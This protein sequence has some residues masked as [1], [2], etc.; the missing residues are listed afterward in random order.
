M[1][2]IKQEKN[3]VIIKT[4]VEKHKIAIQPSDIVRLVLFQHA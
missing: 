1:M 4:Q 2:K 3:K